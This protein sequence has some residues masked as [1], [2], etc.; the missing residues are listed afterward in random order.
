MVEEK[1]PFSSV[2]ESNQTSIGED[3]QS[4]EG[5]APEF[6]RTERSVLD[7]HFNLLTSSNEL[8]F[9]NARIQVMHYNTKLGYI[10]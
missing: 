7:D 3:N 4:S 10:Y 2:G 1:L 9:R 8:R 5:E 6:E